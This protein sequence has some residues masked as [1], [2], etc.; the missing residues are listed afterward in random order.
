MTQ[1][2]V[3]AEIVRK[4]TP[5]RVKVDLKPETLLIE[6]AGIDSARMVDIG[7]DIEDKFKILFEDSVKP[8]TYG[9]LLAYVAKL[10]AQKG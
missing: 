5:R 10:T 1:E 7:L 6:E 3:I 4:Y 2:E 8:K 9:E